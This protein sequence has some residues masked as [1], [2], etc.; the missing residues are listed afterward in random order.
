[1]KFIADITIMPL[2]ELLDPQG[3][4]VNRSLSTLGM[5]QIKDVRIGKHLRIQVE[6]ADRG[7]AE[8]IIQK[9]CDQLLVNKVM[10]SVDFQLKE[11]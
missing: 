9:A 7:E 1:M 10:E 3:K 11:A 8:N 6:A 2:E 5:N 4:A